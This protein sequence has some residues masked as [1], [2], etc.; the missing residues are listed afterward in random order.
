LG[1]RR[2]LRAP[3]DGVLAA[4]IGSS[5]T[6]RIHQGESP[7]SRD[8]PSRPFSSGASGGL[9]DAVGVCGG[10]SWPGAARRIRARPVGACLRTP[11]GR[12]GQGRHAGVAA[13]SSMPSSR[14]STSPW[15][16]RRTRSDALSWSYCSPVSH[17]QRRRGSRTRSSAFCDLRT[18]R[19]DAPSRRR[20]RASQVRQPRGRRCAGE[21]ALLVH[22]RGDLVVAHLDLGPAA[23]A[24]D[25]SG[26]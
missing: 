20:T 8:L 23:H 12:V 9:I 26:R 1:S 4:P 2:R 11:R 17:L 25:V 15:K 22:E 10:P 13:E 5:P 19:P 6:S 3:G 7:S 18:S 21:R 14:E 16:R 24:V